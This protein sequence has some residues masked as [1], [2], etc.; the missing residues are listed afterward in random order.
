MSV[1][2]AYYKRYA[3][4]QKCPVIESKSSSGLSGIA[5]SDIDLRYV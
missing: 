1:S 2:Y 4:V 3:L 5:L